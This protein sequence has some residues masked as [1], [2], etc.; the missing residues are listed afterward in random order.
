MSEPAPRVTRLPVKRRP[1]GAPRSI[2][3][4]E[5]RDL[6]RGIVQ[7]FVVEPHHRAILEQAC[8]ALDRAIEARKLLDEQ[9]LTVAGQKGVMKMHPA[10]AVERDSRVAVARLLR[11]LNLDYETPSV[12]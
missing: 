3:T 6:W 1:P 11:E 8:H 4:R 10:A 12:P 9:G 2:K 5:A 7:Q